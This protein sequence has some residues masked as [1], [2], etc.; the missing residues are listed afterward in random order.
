MKLLKL[1][2]LKKTKNSFY[3]VQLEFVA[4]M[5]FSVTSCKEFINPI[6]KKNKK[7]NLV[8]FQTVANA[9]K[10]FA[11]K[12]SSSRRASESGIVQFVII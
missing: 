11:S 2:D 4:S 1:G 5:L 10:A 7:Y 3:Q 9:R 12:S 8:I 6:D